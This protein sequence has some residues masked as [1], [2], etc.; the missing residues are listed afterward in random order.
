MSQTAYTHMASLQKKKHQNI[1]QK[2]A[3]RKVQTY[4]LK[5]D[6]TSGIIFISEEKPISEKIEGE[7]QRK[8]QEYIDFFGEPGG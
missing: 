4:S 3:I 5:K 6:V 2:D 1:F 8:N 7:K